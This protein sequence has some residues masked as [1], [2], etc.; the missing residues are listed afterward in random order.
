MFRGRKSSAKLFSGDGKDRTVEKMRIMVD[1]TDGLLAR[2]YRATQFIPITGQ[3]L[4]S[5][6]TNIV[7]A[8]LKDDDSKIEDIKQLPTFQY[9]KNRKDELNKES[10]FVVEVFMDLIDTR[11][12]IVNIL[13]PFFSS[14][15]FANMYQNRNICM[16]ALNLVGNLYKMHIIASRMNDYCK[17]AVYIKDIII[18]DYDS[19]EKV[20]VACIFLFCL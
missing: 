4:K 14:I 7:N 3:A 15:V 9:I 12:E 8:V 6:P 17:T 5:L 2:V 16:D 11:N 20:Y 10:E 18:D 19:D 1:Y 13:K